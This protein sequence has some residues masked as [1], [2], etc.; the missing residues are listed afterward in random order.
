MRNLFLAAT[1]L[2]LSAPSALACKVE[3]NYRVPTN[4]ELVEAADVIVLARVEELKKNDPARLTHVA[5]KP[6]RTL[7]GTPP[8]AAIAVPGTSTGTPEVT[9]LDKA[10]KSVGWGS[11]ARSTYTRGT[12]VIAMFEQAPDGLH[13][14]SFPFA[15]TI[16]D[17][18]SRIG[19]WVRAVEVYVKLAQVPAGQR[20]AA[21]EAEVKRLDYDLDDRTASLAIAKDLRAYLKAVPAK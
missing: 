19:L 10:N 9:P 18:D 8:G 6:G 15:R 21:I 5:L 3:A 1:L 16:E 7:K 13:P 14:L 2:L 11:C 12:L 20:R 17:V 4:F